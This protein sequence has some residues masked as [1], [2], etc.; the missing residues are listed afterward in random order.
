MRLTIVYRLEGSTHWE[1]SA[2]MP[3]AGD[4]AKLHARLVTLAER[5]FAP[6]FSDHGPVAEV[7]VDLNGTRYP[8]EHFR[9]DLEV[10]R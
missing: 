8:V 9:V 6:G 3:L 7:A 5:C 10:S 2:S 4:A 1:T